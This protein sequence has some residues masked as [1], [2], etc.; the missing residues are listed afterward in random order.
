MNEGFSRSAISS[1]PSS[2]P[3]IIFTSFYLTFQFH[4]LFFLKESQNIR[5][6][7]IATFELWY[8]LPL[9]KNKQLTL[10]A[11]LWNPPSLSVWKNVVGREIC[12]MLKNIFLWWGV[13]TREFIGWVNSG[14]VVFERWQFHVTADEL[15]IEKN[16][17]WKVQIINWKWIILSKA[18]LEN[19]IWSWEFV[20]KLISGLEYTKTMQFK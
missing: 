6:W 15:K 13:Y 9:C 3:G 7:A 18:N 2:A 4:F 8:S 1:F 12:C 14:C 5:Y 11:S 16:K 10:S 20:E 19:E 17:N